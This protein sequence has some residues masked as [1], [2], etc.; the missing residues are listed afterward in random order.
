MSR[1]GL[2]QGPVVAAMALGVPSLQ[3]RAGHAFA[4]AAILEKVLFEAAARRGLAAGH[5]SGVTISTTVLSEP[6]GRSGT[7]VATPRV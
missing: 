5:H 1:T 2:S 7:C 3:S 4:D 6:C